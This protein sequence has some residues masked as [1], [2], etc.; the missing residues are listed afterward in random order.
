L[1]QIIAVA[2]FDPAAWNDL[3]LQKIDVQL[4]RRN[5]LSWMPKCP[6]FFVN[7][8]IAVK[9]FDFARYKEMP[10]RFDPWDISLFGRGACCDM[11]HS[12]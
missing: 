9:T 2:E 5:K 4:R 7:V 8:R 12:I 10:H 6:G 3:Y 1:K 11:P